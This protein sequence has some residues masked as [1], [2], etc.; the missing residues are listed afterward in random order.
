MHP[1]ATSS[2]HVPV[3]FVFFGFFGRPAAAKG[4]HWRVGRRAAPERQS[5]IP[6][7]GGRSEIATLNRPFLRGRGAAAS[8][9]NGFARQWDTEFGSI[10]LREPLSITKKQP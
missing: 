7:V 3:G 9:L 8:T 4:G 1:P 5:D 2:A 6:T 10:F